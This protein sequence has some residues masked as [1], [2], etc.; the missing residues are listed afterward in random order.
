LVIVAKPD[1]SF[2]WGGHAISGDHA[3]LLTPGGEIDCVSPPGS[4]LF[5]MSVAER[6]LA[7]V[8]PTSRLPQGIEVLSSD[9]VNE[10]RETLHLVC[11]EIA[12]PLAHRKEHELCEKL[13]KGIP[14][15]LYE[16]AA[17]KAGYRQQRDRLR[18]RALERAVEV[19]IEA[20]REP[21]TVNDICRE[22]GVSHRTLE[23]AFQ[24]CFDLSPKAYIRT[25]RLNCVRKE[26]RL[27]DPASTSITKVAV[28]WGF[29][30]M[31]QFAADYRKLF[32]EL[33]T[34]TLGRRSQRKAGE[35]RI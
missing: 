35:P 21:L 1:Q 7:E 16:L 15:Q 14:R 5:T 9:A 6:C 24:A 22:V 17:S 30:H 4:S 10:L 29:R 23:Y 3:V 25:V 27:S 20:I 26:L 32:M 28:R 2:K 34:E 12:E 31:G 19:I 11:R 33:P 8:G 13:E 18:D